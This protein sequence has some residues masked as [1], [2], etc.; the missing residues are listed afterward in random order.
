MPINLAKLGT[1][2]HLPM[3]RDLTPPSILDGFRSAGTPILLGFALL[4]CGP[5]KGCPPGR[6]RQG[7]SRTLE[8]TMQ[9]AVFFPRPDLPFGPEASGA[10]DLSFG[11]EPGVRLRLRFFPGGR[12][13]PNILFFHGNGETARD[14]DDL[15]DQYRSLPASLGVAEYRGY[16]TSTGKPTLDTLLPDAHRTLRAYRAMLASEGRTGP[17]IVMG[18]S[19]GSAP[20]IELAASRE[21]K[22][23]GLVVESGFARFVPLLER[24]GFPATR[25]GI[26]EAQGPRN[27]EKMGT[28]SLP[29]LILHAES[30]EVIPIADAEMLFAAS[31]DAQKT[32]LRVPH[33]GHNDIQPRAGAGYFMALRNLLARVQAE[34]PKP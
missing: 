1:K 29:T 9:D 32:F 15:A 26:S 5:P 10:Q 31:R 12:Q 33:A 25:L 28:I 2:P 22:V 14:Y 20:A 34:S 30:D 24:L 3:G 17:I 23:N 21:A 19:L 13:A 11:V 16:G 27:C 7:E 4:A 18:R 6:A 8:A